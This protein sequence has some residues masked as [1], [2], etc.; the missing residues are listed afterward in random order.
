M[1]LFLFQSNGWDANEMFKFNEEAYGVKSTYDSSLSMY[2]WVQIIRTGQRMYRFLSNVLIIWCYLFSQHAFRE[3]ELW[4]FPSAG[5]S[6][7]SVSQWDREQ[8][9]IPPAGFFRERRGAERGGQIQ[10]GGPREGGAVQPRV[11]LQQ[12]VRVSNQQ[13]I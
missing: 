9:A 3:R 7:S 1:L 12:Q 4:G 11:L 10:L 8:L 5:G 13:V 6:S 2:T